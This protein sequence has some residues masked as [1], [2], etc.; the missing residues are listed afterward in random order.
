MPLW[1]GDLGFVQSSPVDV[2]LLLEDAESSNVPTNTVGE[3]ARCFLKNDRY[4]WGERT[5]V[6]PSWGE[7]TL[8]IPIRGMLIDNK[9]V[10][11][12]THISVVFF[13]WELGEFY[14]TPT[15]EEG[16]IHGL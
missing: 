2:A 10:E 6:T 14:G 8:V 11:C 5:T 9:M 3:G 16:L 4:K 13:L 7:I 15:K 12:S 1:F